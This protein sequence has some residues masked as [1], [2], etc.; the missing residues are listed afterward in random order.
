[1]Y[2]NQ[3]L[4]LQAA[5]A[6]LSPFVDNETE[7][8]IPD[9]QKE[10]NSLAGIETADIQ[11][12]DADDSS[13]SEA[14]DQQPAEDTKKASKKV[15]DDLDSSS[16]ED[17]DGSDS[18]SDE[19]VKVKLT[20][21]EIAKQNAKLKQDLKKEKEELG[22]MVMTKR[23]R[24]LYQEAEKTQKAKKEATKKLIQKKK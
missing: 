7:G 13:E 16:D 21:K 2:F 5:P 20:K 24:K 19:P 9:R 1:M 3:F 11:H 15:K 6:H 14:E 22:K 8:Y 4:F 12:S 10:I 18:E 17:G 23:Q